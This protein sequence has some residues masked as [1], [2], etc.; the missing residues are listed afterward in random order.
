[1]KEMLVDA[2]DWSSKTQGRG[3]YTMQLDHYEELQASLSQ[4]LM[5]GKGDS[6]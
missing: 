5:N 3:S 2:T 6:D 4:E 1:M